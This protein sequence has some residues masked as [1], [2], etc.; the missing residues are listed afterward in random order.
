MSEGEER[1]TEQRTKAL[2]ARWHAGDEVALRELIGL[3]EPWIAACVRRQLGNALRERVESGDMVNETVCRLVRMLRG[4]SHPDVQDGQHLRCLIER[5]VVR[6]ICDQNDREEAGRRAAGRHAVP[7]DSAQHAA[8][9]SGES[10]SRVAE[11]EQM[12]R[13]VRRAIELLPPEDARVIVM[14]AWDRA[15]FEEIGAALGINAA[16]ADTRYRRA[17]ARMTAK[18]VELDSS[19]SE[20]RR[21][22]ADPRS[23]SA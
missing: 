21:D 1:E 18:L 20:Q 15:S 10:P 14:R 7:L 19:S 13:R 11:V 2:L 12:R 6:V 16:A 22:S 3:H 9:A 17:L 23:P 8:C 5:L 4:E